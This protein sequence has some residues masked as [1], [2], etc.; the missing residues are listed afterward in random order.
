[1]QTWQ[2]W[3]FCCI[4]RGVIHG[5]KAIRMPCHKLPVKGVRCTITFCTLLLDWLLAHAFTQDRNSESI[6]F[7]ENVLTTACWMICNTIFTYSDCMCSA[8]MWNHSQTSVRTV[9]IGCNNLAWRRLKSGG[10]DTSPHISFA[11]KAQI[12]V[13]RSEIL[14]GAR[15]QTKLDKRDWLNALAEEKQ[16]LKAVSLQQIWSADLGRGNRPGEV[17]SWR[18]HYTTGDTQCHI[19]RTLA[20]LIFSQTLMIKV[21]S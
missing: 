15:G 8:P 21:W 7:R 10:H 2:S 6:T 14:A 20:T 17:E 11:F 16:C 13:L 9:C 5:C 3:M 4:C 12:C 1:M 18:L 19:L